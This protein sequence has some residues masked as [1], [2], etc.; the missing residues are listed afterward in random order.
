M[1]GIPGVLQKLILLEYILEVRA[2]GD[3]VQAKD[4]KAREIV[5]H[6]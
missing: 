3:I 1:M 5:E 2:I 6:G 4:V